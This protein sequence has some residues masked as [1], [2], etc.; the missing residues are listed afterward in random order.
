[1]SPVTNLLAQPSSHRFLVYFGGISSVSLRCSFSKRRH[2][3]STR[4]CLTGGM[5]RTRKDR[6]LS[7][8]LYCCSGSVSHGLKFSPTSPFSTEH[9]GNLL[10]DDSGKPGKPETRPLPCHGGSGLLRNDPGHGRAVKLAATGDSSSGQPFVWSNR[11]V[12]GLAELADA[13]V[14]KTSE[15]NLISVRFRYPPPSGVIP[16]NQSSGLR[17]ALRRE[18]LSFPVL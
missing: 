14:S 13:E 10:R 9:T 5:F 15:S 1:M 17:R 18:E 12:G 8:S 6:R 4:T 11:D 16:K 2:W 7:R 3:Q